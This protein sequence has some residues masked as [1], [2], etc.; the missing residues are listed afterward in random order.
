MNVLLVEDEPGIRSLVCTHLRDQGL[1]VTVAATIAEAE[2]ALRL[3]TYVVVIL[4]LSL[5]DGSGLE[6][7]D[8]LQASNSRSHVIILSGSTAEA[9][10]VRALQRG[11]D[12][13]V[14]KPFY[15]REL[16]ARVLAVGRRR[17]PV[18]DTA[19]RI[20]HFD[21][22]L[23]SRVVTSGGQKIELT[24]KEF[25][26][27]AY[28][29]VRPG[30]VFDREE[31]LN[32][33]WQS[34]GEWQQEA[35]VTE[36]IRRL[37][38]KLEVDPAHPTLITTVRGAGYRLDLPT[39]QGEG[40]AD[41]G[42][43]AAVAPGEVIHVDGLIV[44]CDQEAANL[45][46][47]AST[48]AVVGTYVMEFVG[49][50][51]LAAARGRLIET[52]DG[53]TRRSELMEFRQGD[54]GELTVAVQSTP[55]EWHGQPARR[56]RL[57]PVTDARARLRRLVTGVLADL[58]D[59]VIVTDL[60]FHILSWNSAAE[61]LYGWSEEDVRGRHILDV[62]HWV[63]DSEQLPE[64]WEKLERSGRWHGESTQQTRDGSVV[65]VLNSTSIVRDE[66]GEPVGIV[67]VNRTAVEARRTRSMERDTTLVAR[68]RQGLADGEFRVH[69]QP[70]IDLFDGRLSTLEAL[71]RWEHPE[72]GTLLPSEFIDTAERSGLIVEMGEFV[73][74]EACRQAAEWRGS[75][76]DI[77]LSVNVSTR[78]L[79]DPGMV[80]RF[81]D[82][83][84]E[85]GLD[86]AF[87]WLEVTETAVVEG[88]ERA[89][90]VLR[91]LVDLGV[92]VA[93]DDF[94]TGWAS[95]T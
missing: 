19:L 67:F 43:A 68:L 53:P 42:R 1:Y 40:A 83:L 58:T 41:V 94:G 61:R 50:T 62:L 29:A 57:T 89:S 60:H 32:A 16:T 30:H 69:Y 11:A 90:H 88:L 85:S 72:R 65:E 84:R 2:V 20:G 93:I 91:Q 18:A 9:S 80:Q 33:V 14:V 21:I 77:Q 66:G 79:A 51:S 36:H 75:G 87:L 23:L 22:D 12:D 63:G 49:Q 7:L 92:G 64:M 45:L 44:S 28:L 8:S 48:S 46:G 81:T 59:A 4:D 5:P 13:F 35:T 6:I 15:L 37:R 17:D 54:A 70:V 3:R 71:V 25:D 82:I 74:G 31:L 78:Q 73:L 47:A 95:L 55:V 10:R 39:T 56:L 27:L 38:G 52:G 34:T 76:A 24:A 86:P 26:L